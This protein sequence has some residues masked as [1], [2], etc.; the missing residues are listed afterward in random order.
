MRALQELGSL[1]KKEGKAAVQDIN[2]RESVGLESSRLPMSG[3]KVKKKGR[4]MSDSDGFESDEPGRAPSKRRSSK[5]SGGSAP[6]KFEKMNKPRTER[7]VV[8]EEPRPSELILGNKKKLWEPSAE[9]V[10]AAGFRG[11]FITIDFAEAKELKALDTNILKKG[12]GA[13]DPYIK[14]LVNGEKEVHKTTV[15]SSTL[16]PVWKEKCDFFVSPEEKIIVLQIYDYDRVGD[17]DSMGR[18]TINLEEYDP[19]EMWEPHWRDVEPDEECPDATGKLLLTVKFE[20]T[21]YYKHEGGEGKLEILDAADLIAVDSAFVGKATSD[22]YIVVKVDGWREI[23]KTKVKQNTLDPKWDE[24]VEFKLLP[25]EI[26]LTFELFDSDIDADDPMGITTFEVINTEI[27][28]QKKPYRIEE[29]LSILPQQAC[30]TAKGRL[31]IVMSYEPWKPPPKPKPE[32]REVQGVED[33]PQNPVPFA[34]RSL[35]TNEDH[36]LWNVT[37]VGRSERKLRDGVDLRLD[38]EDVSSIHAAIE[39]YGDNLREW[40]IQVTDESSTSGTEVDGKLVLPGTPFVIE[41]GA[42]IRF[43]RKEMWILERK[44]LKPRSRLPKAQDHLFIENEYNLKI[45]DIE[46]L[47]T[48]LRCPEWVDFTEV[49]L[50]KMGLFNEAPCAD[51]IEIRD[52]SNALISTHQVTTPEEMNDYNMVDV[53]RYIDLGGHIILRLTS[54]P[55]LLAPMVERHRLKK[56]ELQKRMEERE[57]LE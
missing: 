57:D 19:P 17:D 12:G 38:S 16:A 42:A 30:P 34:L 24:T 45:S 49:F 3:K 14:V 33:I 32:K 2:P 53:L 21:K 56:A 41:T 9:E 20:Q 36:R 27:P 37:F 51:Y 40:V 26:S 43:G 28:K 55:Y 15:K 7:S 5:Q 48:L 10:A 11:G 22:P 18:V 13:S 6:G 47:N 29:E 1:L 52:D 54:D 31:R 23:H 25:G 46:T 39:I 50:E 35:M 4:P 44:A 8:I